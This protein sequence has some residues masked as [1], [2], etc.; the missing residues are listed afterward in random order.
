[1]TYVINANNNRVSDPVAHWLRILAKKYDQGVDVRVL[2]DYPK[3]NRPNYHCNSYYIRWLHDKGIP[4]RCLF[5]AVTMHGKMVV[6]DT[7]HLFIGSHNW[8][9]SSLKNPSEVS[10]QVSD[11]AVVSDGIDTFLQLW[12]RGVH[13]TDQ[14]EKGTT[15]HVCHKGPDIR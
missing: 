9:P 5:S 11:P 13:T 2:T 6:V 10:L 14:V 12:K 8:S 15:N 1:M 4:V 7:A 3:R